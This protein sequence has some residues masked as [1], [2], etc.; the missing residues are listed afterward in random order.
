MPGDA[1]AL[2]WGYEAGHPFDERA[3]ALAAAGL[4]F[5]LCPG[6]SSWNSFAGRLDNALANLAEAARAGAA[7][8]ASGYLITDWGDNGH[9]QPWPVSWP[10]LV[11]GAAFAWRPEAA[12]DPSSLDLANLVDRVA[13]PG[14]A[15][16]TG[17]VLTELGNVYRQVGVTPMNSSALFKLVKFADRPLAD[18]GLATLTAVELAST[19]SAVSATAARIASLPTGGASTG[20]TSPSAPREPAQ[21]GIP[22][23]GSEDLVR[24]ELDWVAGMLRFAC[25]LG[26]SRLTH[27]AQQRLADLPASQR[28]ALARELGRRIEEL[29]PLWLARSRPGGLEDSRARLDR[30]LRLLS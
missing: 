20:G 30:V 4:E 10:A 28:R 15:P 26:R 29:P 5:Y 3:A 6:T 21:R 12:D 8:G 17:A 25:R 11:A 24:R 13:E 16:G 23:G 1:I 27:G 2:D 18:S 14:L 19:E 22:R 9:L 7:H